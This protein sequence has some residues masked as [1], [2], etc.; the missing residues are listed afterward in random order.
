MTESSLVGEFLDK[1]LEPEAEALGQPEWGQLSCRRYDKEVLG[2]IEQRE[3]KW[4]GQGSWGTCDRHHFPPCD[5]TIRCLK[6]Y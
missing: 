4:V 1:P 2:Y 5:T 6:S 3:K